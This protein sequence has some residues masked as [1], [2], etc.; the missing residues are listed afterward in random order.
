MILLRKLHTFNALSTAERR[1]FFI[2]LGLYPGIGL[3]LHIMGFKRTFS[4]L[5]S[6]AG[7]N[8][9]SSEE[10]RVYEILLN[11]H[12]VFWL[13][14][15][16]IPYKGTCLSRSMLL[17]WLL[18]REGVETNLRIGVKKDQEVF[19][20]HAWLEYKTIVLNDL[21]RIDEQYAPISEGIK[22]GR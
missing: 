18:R 17:Y 1:A 7:V 20:A 3:S 15:R 2:S 11:T 19:K 21:Q 4:W 12:Q 6:T 22:L 5:D 9:P 10:K 14:K 16:Y 8:S 13:V